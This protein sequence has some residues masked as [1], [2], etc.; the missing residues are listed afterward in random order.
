MDSNAASKDNVRKITLNMLVLGM[1]IILMVTF[2]SY[3]IESEPDLK[4]LEM[5]MLADNF[6]SNVTNSRWQWIAENKPA[7]ILLIEYGLN[8]EREPVEIDRRPIPMT[9]LGW[10]KATPDN[11]GCEKLWKMI[12][13]MP[14]EVKRFR[15]YAEYYDGIDISGQVLD[16][17]CKF[18]LSTGPEFE[19]LIYTGRVIKTNV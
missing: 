6:S 7:R 2:I 8:D 14:L 13:D 17:R 9:H 5:E 10:P 4:K 3:F 19:Y 15:V 1:F 18:R 12:L 16:S 11:V